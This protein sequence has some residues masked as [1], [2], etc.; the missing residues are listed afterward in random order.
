[1]WQEQSALL[2]TSI[3]NVP[4]NV[5]SKWSLLLN[6][7]KIYP[8]SKEPSVVLLGTHFSKGVA[9]HKA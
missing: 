1:M 2:A 6:L 4:R 8:T 5:N 9:K 7:A 3:Y